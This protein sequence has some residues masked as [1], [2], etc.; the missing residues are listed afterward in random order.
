MSVIDKDFGLNAEV[1]FETSDERF[2]VVAH[3]NNP[4]QGFIRATE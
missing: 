4:Q 1:M 3:P 2:T